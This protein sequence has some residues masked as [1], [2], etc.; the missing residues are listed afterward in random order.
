MEADKKRKMKA[1]VGLYCHECCSTDVEIE[2]ESLEDIE[3]QATKELIA[4]VRNGDW[5]P[6]SVEV[7]AGWRILSV[8]MD[9]DEVGEE[10]TVKIELDHS[11]KICEA[12]ERDGFS[13]RDICGTDPDDHEWTSEGEGGDP[14]NPG[15]RSNG[16]SG[17]SISSHCRVCGLHMLK[18]TAVMWDEPTFEYRMLTEEEIE[19]HRQQ[20]SMDLPEEDEDE[21][22]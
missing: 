16:N 20:G 14:E 15:I 12:L 4:W 8:E 6:D 1:K 10:M 22:E 17:L 7:D 2:G 19:W 9:E 18:E 21:G 11:R 5:G 3:T 13:V